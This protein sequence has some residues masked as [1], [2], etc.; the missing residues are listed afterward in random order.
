[1]EDLFPS[2]SPPSE[3]SSVEAQAS[4]HR[5]YL[6][7]IRVERPPWRENDELNYYLVVH[8]RTKAWPY[9]HSITLGFA[10][11]LVAVLS[12]RWPDHVAKRIVAFLVLG[13]Q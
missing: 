10:R 6:S 3:N 4:A 1:M 12:R 5:A 8:R 11:Y 13:Q 2:E 9:L 7:E